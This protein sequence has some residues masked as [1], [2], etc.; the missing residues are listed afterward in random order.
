MSRYKH[1]TLEVF[2]NFMSN[3]NY[4]KRTI[5][6]YSCYVIEF[7]KSFQKDAYHINQNEVYDYL[8]SY[9]YTS[10]SKQNQVINSIKLFCLH[11]LKMKFRD[12]KIERPRK[13]HKLP[14]VLSKEEIHR[15]ILSA[16]N[17]KHKAMIM[18]LYSSGIRRE[19]L[20]NLKITDIDSNRMVINVIAGKGK[21][22]RITLLDNNVLNVLR[23][24]FK[25]YKPKEYL[26]ENPKGGKYSATS[27]G[28]FIKKYAKLARINRYVTPHK[29]RHS[30]ATHLLESGTDIRLIQHL[31]GH[32]SSKTTEIYTHV[33]NR[34]VSKVNSPIS[35]LVL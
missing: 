3:K 20:L 26:F 19:E 2:K 5:D 24:Y 21:K 32:T 27:V 35:K 17:I 1:N 8:M 11:V 9:N 10:I 4:S 22:D 16:S 15:L 31:L 23:E 29:L 28:V 12:V 14:I 33:S 6:I 25:K 13:E 34:F 30:F 7:I 18:V